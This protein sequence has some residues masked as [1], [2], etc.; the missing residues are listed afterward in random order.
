MLI[1]DRDTTA[2]SPNRCPVCQKYKPAQFDLCSKCQ[3]EHGKARDQWPD[4]LQDL[5]RAERS[6]LAYEN[7]AGRIEYTPPRQYEIAVD[8]DGNVYLE[9]VEDDEDDGLLEVAE[10]DSYAAWAQFEDDLKA[11][12]ELKN[13][14][15]RAD[16]LGDTS[17]WSLEGLDKDFNPNQYFG[18]PVPTNPS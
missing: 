16:P 9:V 2:P 5:V 15:H 4:W 10:L 18:D 8:E 14:A 7:R 13:A 6:W 11:A 3:V 1:S 17:F 12:E